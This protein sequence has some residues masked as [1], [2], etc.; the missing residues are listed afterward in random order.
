VTIAAF[1][2]TTRLEE[3]GPVGL[4]VFSNE[5]GNVLDAPL[6]GDLAAALAEVDGRPHLRASVLAADGKNFCSGA[7]L[8]NDGEFDP[9]PIYR[10]ALRIFAVRKPIVAAVQGAA[11]GGGLGL[12]LA[13]DFRVVATET[14]FSANFVKIGIHPGFGLTV[15]LPRVVGAQ[16]AALLCLTGRRIGGE[17]AL[18]LGLADLLV[19]ADHLRD[20]ALAIAAELADGAPLAVEA[21][22]A[23]LRAGL[24]EAVERQLKIEIEQQRKLFRTEDFSEGLLATRERRV[25]RWTRS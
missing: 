21:T 18:A 16:T 6:V 20:R 7:S 3:R 11:I 25:G 17:E 24:V 15:V 23:T 1:G 5:P 12:A 2:S 8:G 22:R 10:S 13:A 19:P 9:E 4:V 14:K